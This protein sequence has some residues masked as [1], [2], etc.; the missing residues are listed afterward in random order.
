MITNPR[1]SIPQWAM[2]IARIT[3]QRGTC[4]RRKV[5]C[6]ILDDYHNLVSVGY[7]GLAEEYTRNYCYENHLNDDG[8]SSRLHAC[9]GASSPSGQNL[10]QCYAIHAEQMALLKA[11]YKYESIKSIYI[12]HSPC[13]SC[14][15]VLLHTPIHTIVFDADYT[16]KETAKNLWLKDRY[17][18][19]SYRVWKSLKEIENDLG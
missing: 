8:S 12:T 5:G 2:S 10:D 19:D 3:A 1:I 7:N 13:I 17:A 9:P 6:V 16:D 4:A 14:V 18:L 15:K 11:N